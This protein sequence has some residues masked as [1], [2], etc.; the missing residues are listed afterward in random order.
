MISR[1]HCHFYNATIINDRNQTLHR[2]TQISSYAY[3]QNTNKCVYISKFANIQW[4]ILGGIDT[5]SSPCNNGST[6]RIWGWL[7]NLK[8]LVYK[9][10]KYRQRP[11]HSLTCKSDLKRRWHIIHLIL[12]PYKCPHNHYLSASLIGSLEVLCVLFV[13]ILDTTFWLKLC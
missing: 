4:Y 2:H 3:R 13:L 12:N 5:P 10:N 8:C 9:K 11:G 7:M 6:E 1:C